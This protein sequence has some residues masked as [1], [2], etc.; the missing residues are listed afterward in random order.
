MRKATSVLTLV[1]ALALL[2]FTA[3]SPAA[4]TGGENNNPPGF[5]GTVKIHVSP[6]EPDPVQ[7]NQPKVC[8]LH[9]HGFQFD[10]SA[11]G[12]WKID[13]QS[14][15]SGSAAGPENWGPADSNGDW[16]SRAITIPPGHYKLSF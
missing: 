11:M 4:A 3:S 8:V 2:A 16:K 1:V 15:G 9:I 12:W 5:N 14:Q 6:G 7:R 10:A 13:W